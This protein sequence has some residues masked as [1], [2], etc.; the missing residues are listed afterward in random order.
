M[1]T[2]I[3][4]ETPKRSSS[5]RAP[6]PAAEAAWARRRARLASVRVLL[7]FL[8]AA[9]LGVG[10]RINGV[11]GATRDLQGI[12]ART[13]SENGPPET[14]SHLAHRLAQEVYGEEHDEEAAARYESLVRVV[15]KETNR[16]DGRLDRFG[17]EARTTLLRNSWFAIGLQAL[18]LVF[19][20]GLLVSG[21]LRAAQGIREAEAEPP[22]TFAA[23]V[24]YRRYRHLL[25]LQEHRFFWRRLGFALLM[26]YGTIYLVAPLGVKAMEIGNYLTLNAIPGEPTYPFLLI[27]FQK[28]P[29][30]SVGFAGFYLYALTLF[31]RRYTTHDLNDRIYVPLFLRGVTVV[32]LGWVLASI[33]EESGLSRALIFAVGIFPQ[34]G[35]QALAK[36]TQTT[37]DRLSNEGGSAFKTIPEIDFWKETTLQEM[38]INDFN[39]LAKA[40]L[41]E[42]LVDLGMNPAVLMRAVDRAV[43]IHVFGAEAAD[44]L[45][46]IPLFTASDLVLYTR[47]QAAWADRWVQHGGPRFPRGEVLDAQQR[48]AREQIVEEAIGAK[49][50]GLQLEHL[51][52]DRNVQTVID[53]LVSYQS[54]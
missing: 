44:K 17:S 4:Q 2:K 49:D 34:A 9:A 12:A 23:H 40:N 32:L 24:W 38:G 41:D 36:M 50:I 15:A 42:L 21:F 28:A 26:G 19:F 13:T 1:R 52:H 8:I 30:F 48:R 10:Q 18:L 27:A 3:E 43:L 16:L 47:G 35:L 14:I 29:P 37:V 54:L 6:D 31:V 53:N 7:P 33:G 25:Q 45:A 46:A 5:D 11:L 39:D 51:I 20:P 22:T